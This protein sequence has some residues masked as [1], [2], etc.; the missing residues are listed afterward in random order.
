MF[1][2]SSLG[3]QPSSVKVLADRGTK[4]LTNDQ[5]CDFIAAKVAK[6]RLSR[7]NAL[8][9][10]RTPAQTDFLLQ[11]E[12]S[13]S[14]STFIV[15][16][17]KTSTSGNDNEHKQSSNPTAFQRHTVTVGQGRKEDSLRTAKSSSEATAQSDKKGEQ[18]A[19]KHYSL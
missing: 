12:S 19:S 1:F 15:S 9:T 10:N 18:A 3:C 7:N 13:T 2:P 17:P 5:I 8:F 4:P 6:F 14:H 16:P 11:P